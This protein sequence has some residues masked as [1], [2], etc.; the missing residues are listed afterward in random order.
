VA[1]LKARTGGDIQVW[2]STQLVRYLVG[3]DLIDEY[4]LMIEPILLG[5]GK[6]IFP[7]DGTA[8]TLTLQSVIPSPSGVLIASYTRA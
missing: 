4:R 7:D 1:A 5:G 3:E 8:R 2:G 6:R